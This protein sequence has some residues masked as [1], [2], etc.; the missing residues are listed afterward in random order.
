[1]EYATR[2]GFHG[3]GLQNLGGARFRG[4]DGTW[5]HRGVGVEA[6]LLMKGAM[7]VGSRLCRVR[8]ECLC[9]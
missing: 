4:T 1:M 6:K 5:R 2:G 7:A 9:G 8:L 3:F